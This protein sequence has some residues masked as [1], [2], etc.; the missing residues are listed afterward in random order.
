MFLFLHRWRIALCI[1][2]L[3][4]LG[5]QVSLA[6]LEPTA[7]KPQ[8]GTPGFQVPEQLKAASITCKIDVYTF[9]CVLV[10]VFGGCPIWGDLQ[11]IY[12]VGVEGKAP[13][14]D[15]VPQEICDLS[16]LCFE[17]EENQA[18]VLRM[19]CK[20]GV[21]LWISLL[22]YCTV[23]SLQHVLYIICIFCTILGT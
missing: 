8:C 15:H 23:L 22:T 2:T 1:R 21:M 18:T 9:G 17:D 12:K 10:V 4:I 13:S 7:T 5:W 11:P 3:L 19:H 20:K 6:V 14:T 16:H